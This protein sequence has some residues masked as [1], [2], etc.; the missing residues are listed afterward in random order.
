VSK[1]KY[2]F[3]RHALERMAERNISRVVVESVVEE[4]E[5]IREYADDTPYPSRLL[6]GWRDERPL[7][8]VAADDDTTNETY[9]ITVYEPDPD[10]WEE[11]FRSKKT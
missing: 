7:H 11:D 1:R 5:V 9:I 10:V 8:V 4:G 2:I 6:L 3:R